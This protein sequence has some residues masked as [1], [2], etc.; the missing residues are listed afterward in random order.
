[1]KDPMDTHRLR[2]VLLRFFAVVATLVLL[3]AGALVALDIP[4][5]AAGM[6]AKGVCSAAFVAGRPWQ[7]LLADDVLPASPALAP[8]GV[9]VDKVCDAVT[10]AINRLTGVARRTAELSRVGRAIIV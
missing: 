5:N 1:M 9:Q 4:R 8:I 2:S 6:A 10:I 7:S 3:L